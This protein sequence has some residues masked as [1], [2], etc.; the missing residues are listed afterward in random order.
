MCSLRAAVEADYSLYLQIHPDLKCDAK[1]LPASEWVHSSMPNA[2]IYEVNGRPIGYAC[3]CCFDSVFYI[4]YLVIDQ[5]HRRSGHGA[6]ALGALKELA[7]ERGFMRYGL[8]SDTAHPLTSVLP[9]KTSMEPRHRLHHIKAAFGSLQRPTQENSMHFLA[10][11]CESEKEWS[12]LETKYGLWHG[13]LR[14]GHKHGLKPITLVHSEDTVGFAMLN[15]SSDALEFW[16]LSVDKMEHVLPFI[17]AMLALGLHGSY[18]G[19]VD[20]WIQPKKHIADYILANV[21]GSV[22]KETFEYLEGHV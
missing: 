12:E 9:T 17:S 10:V 8:H 3:Y 4:D 19:S 5:A 1:P 2:V 21:R 14:V 6:Q 18:A 22:L 20:F 13:L 7:R 16:N 11:L 15:S